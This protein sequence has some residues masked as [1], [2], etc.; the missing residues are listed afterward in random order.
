MF[1]AADKGDAQAALGLGQLYLE[2]ACGLPKD[3]ALARP[4]LE[5]AAAQGLGTATE[6]LAKL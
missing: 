2:G 5:K 6:L 1:Q 4:W 3:A